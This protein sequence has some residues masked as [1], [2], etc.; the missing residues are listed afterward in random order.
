V[1]NLAPR[2]AKIARLG[3]DHDNEARLKRLALEPAGGRAAITIEYRGSSDVRRT[4]ARSL[5]YAG[6]LIL[7]GAAP[8]TFLAFQSGMA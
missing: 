6:A 1:G 8:E 4:L 3:S 2:P 5:L 7:G